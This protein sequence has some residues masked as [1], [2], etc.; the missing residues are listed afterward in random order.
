MDEVEREPEKLRR[1]REE[2][3]LE[4]QPWTLTLHSL[5]NAQS[6]VARHLHE[7]ERSM[8]NWANFYK[9]S[10]PSPPQEFSI[11]IKQC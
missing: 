9:K 10:L 5:F 4:E 2:K 6:M 8:G 7:N 1:V 11:L 3:S